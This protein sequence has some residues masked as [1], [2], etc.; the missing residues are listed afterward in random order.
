MN[1][2][3]LAGLLIIFI[4]FGVGCVTTP[5]LNNYI[6]KG[7]TEKSLA[8]IKSGEKI[9][10]T[11]KQGL[12]AIHVA[13]KTGN[14]RVL[15]A[16]ISKGVDI[17]ISD[18]N[19]FMSPIHYAASN[20]NTTALT[21]LI[22]GGVNIN[23]NDRRGRTALKIAARSGNMN[24]VRVLVKAGANV[25]TLQ[26]VSSTALMDAISGKHQEVV[27]FLIA[28]GAN[29]SGKDDNGNTPVILSSFKGDLKTI[30]YLISHGA[31]IT[32]TNTMG[33]SALIVA[34]YFGNRAIVDFSLTNGANVNHRT[35]AGRSPLHLSAIG[36]NTQVMNLLIK[37]GARPIT[38]NITEEDLFGTAV[39]H[40]TYALWLLRNKSDGSPVDY[41]ITAISY[42][43]KAATEYKQ[44]ERHM[45]KKLAKQALLGV[46]KI[47]FVAYGA[48]TQAHINARSSG[49][50]TGY[51]YGSVRLNGARNLND[52]KNIIR[53]KKEASRA[54]MTKF[55]KI[56]ACIQITP[57]N[58][59]IKCIVK[60]E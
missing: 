6:E 58:A 31:K 57:R 33:Y 13:A 3:K 8:Y 19:Y 46:L 53:A 56:S 36:E 21:L 18:R 45:S 41:L 24:A 42:Y 55:T 32:E 25:N 54:R 37:N 30:K 34:S 60:G 28:S 1:K 26:G 38:L 43:K 2:G 49:T 51:G 9:N 39:S 29:V 10:M 11:D 50:G 35:K 52:I 14:I 12:S 4:L 59:Q 15:K 7:K 48:H 16:L 44:I 5:K 27:R 20:K 22:K 17:N 23:A 40:S 47:M